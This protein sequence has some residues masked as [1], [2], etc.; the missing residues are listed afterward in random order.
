M[1]FGDK[2]AGVGVRTFLRET[3]R[4]RGWGPLIYGTDPDPQAAPR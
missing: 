4:G 1:V 3:P 2:E